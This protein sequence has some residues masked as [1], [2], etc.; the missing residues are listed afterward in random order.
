MTEAL[1]NSEYYVVN[2][3]GD[4]LEILDSVK[5]IS[6]N[7]FYLL[8]QAINYDVL[9]RFVDVLAEDLIVE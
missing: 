7:G 6:I 1:E 4:V 3:D 8:P 2:L 9:F 5:S